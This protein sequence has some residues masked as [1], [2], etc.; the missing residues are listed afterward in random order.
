MSLILL[1]ISTQ[2][3]NLIGQKPQGYRYTL[4]KFTG[5]TPRINSHVRQDTGLVSTLRK[6][7]NF[8]KAK[9]A[10]CKANTTT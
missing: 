1:K 7:W 4:D 9:F 6:C 5:S 8:M 2:H 3:A 10:I